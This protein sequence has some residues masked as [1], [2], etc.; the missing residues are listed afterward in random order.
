MPDPVTESG[1]RHVY[2]PGSTAVLALDITALILKVNIGREGVTYLV[3]WMD[4]RTRH[5]EWVDEGELC[6]PD[7]RITI[8]FKT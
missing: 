3:A 6:N 8:G 5:E 4:G 1:V 7:R 2:A